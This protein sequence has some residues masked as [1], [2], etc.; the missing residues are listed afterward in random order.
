[1]RVVQKH[2]SRFVLIRIFSP[3]PYFLRLVKESLLQT[4]LQLF[5]HTATVAHTHE[6]CCGGHDSQTL[7]TSVY[8]PN[9]LRALAF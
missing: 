6:T 5:I 2:V 7:G 3:H 4:L 1:M 8:S 9:Q